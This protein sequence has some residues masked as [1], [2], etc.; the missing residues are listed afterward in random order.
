MFNTIKSYC[1]SLERAE[2]I[3]CPHLKFEHFKA[4]LFLKIR[5]LIYNHNNHHPWLALNNEQLLKIAGLWQNNFQGEGYTLAAVLLLGKDEV[6]QKLLPHYKIEIFDR[7]HE[8][9]SHGGYECIRTN[10]IDAYDKL[11]D[12]INQRAR[13]RNGM[14]RE[15][16]GN[17]IVH[18]EYMHDH[19][20]TLILHEDRIETINANRPNGE[21][22][23]D[24]KRFTPISKN[25]LISKFFAQLGRFNGVG[26]GMLNLSKAIKINCVNGKPVFIEGAIFRMQVPVLR[27]GSI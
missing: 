21:G 6:I 4:D 12:F 9:H 26:S 25:P 14:L 8:M 17:L 19:A 18:R 1:M 13:L 16:V 11:I 10:L 3:I 20:C 23:I 2:N 7:I 5:N 22:P 15:I 24:F 27:S